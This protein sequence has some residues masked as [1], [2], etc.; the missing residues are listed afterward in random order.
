MS[1]RSVNGMEVTRPR[2]RNGDRAEGKTP[3]QANCERS[4]SFASLMRRRAH[5]RR[6]RRHAKELRAS[7]QQSRNPNS[8]RVRK[9][10]DGRSPRHGSKTPGRSAARLRLR[11]GHGPSGQRRLL[12]E[13]HERPSAGRRRLELRRTTT[14]ELIET[15]AQRVSPTRFCVRAEEATKVVDF[16]IPEVWS[17][18]SKARAG[19]FD[20]RRTSQLSR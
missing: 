18:V 10:P 8:H 15:E 4:R 20:R 9:N 13:A 17:E 19:R 1:D 3:G 11:P 7:N 5:D 14:N 16:A 2:K 12:V 6:G